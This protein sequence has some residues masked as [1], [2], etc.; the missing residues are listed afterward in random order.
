MVRGR[1]RN[2]VSKVNNHSRAAGGIAAFLQ[3]SF[4]FFCLSPTLPCAHTAFAYL[5][6]WLRPQNL[7]VQPKAQVNK[8]REIEPRGMSEVC[9]RRQRAG[10]QLRYSV[11]KGCRDPYQQIDILLMKF[12]PEAAR[13]SLGGSRIQGKQLEFSVAAAPEQMHGL[14][15]WGR[16]GGKV[17]AA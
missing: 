3:F 2:E 4:I 12:L 9:C 13:K 5:L 11:Q 14:G 10:L 8:I 16:V 6:L 7:E 15:S 17:S 1:R